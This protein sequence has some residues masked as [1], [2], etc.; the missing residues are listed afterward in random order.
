MSCRAAAALL[1]RQ[2]GRENLLKAVIFWGRRARE[3]YEELAEELNTP[4]IRKE[5]SRCYD[6]LAVCCREL[7]DEKYIKQ[8]LE[9]GEKDMKLSLR[10]ER[11][12]KT[13]EA[14]D[15]LGYTCRNLGDL[16]KAGHPYQDLEKALK[17]YQKAYDI[18][19]EADRRKQT[20]ES[21]ENV[22]ICQEC[23]AD[24][25]FVAEGLTDVD[26]AVRMQEEALDTSRKRAEALKTKESRQDL[27]RTCLRTGDLYMCLESPEKDWWGMALRLYREAA[28]AALLNQEENGMQADYD[29]V[30]AAASRLAGHPYVP[31]DERKQHL[32]LVKTVAGIAAKKCPDPK[33]SDWISFCERELKELE[34]EG[35]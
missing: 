29:D 28:G 1:Y 18:F 17:L 15:D 5:L 30:A 20:T 16:Y 8:A 3:I 35:Q 22:Q 6:L 23:L 24:I 11:E 25:C 34:E 27:L 19:R 10:L 26:E 9:W 21:M 7:G 12:L 4:E 2:G 33:Y 31:V 32:Y 13:L 14:L